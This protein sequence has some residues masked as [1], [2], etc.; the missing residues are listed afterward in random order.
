MPNRLVADSVNRGELV[1]AKTT[2]EYLSH[3]I[4][5]EAGF[6]ATPTDTT[7]LQRLAHILGMRSRRQVA[8]LNT[9]GPVA[10]MENVQASRDFAAKQSVADPVCVHTPVASAVNPA[11]AVP[12]QVAPPVPAAFFRWLFRHDPA[13]LLLGCKA[14]RYGH[15][16]GL[17]RKHCVLRVL[18]LAH[19]LTVGRKRAMVNE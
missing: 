19:P 12:L 15:G 18:D 8:R 16:E 17:L 10:A 3:L 7:A 6:G 14:V 2:S 11:V 1:G 9:Y 13:E 5:I 4:L